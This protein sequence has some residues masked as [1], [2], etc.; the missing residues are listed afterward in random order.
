MNL[1]FKLFYVIIFYF[2]IAFSCPPAHC[3]CFWCT[4]CTW[5]DCCSFHQCP[6]FFSGRCLFSCYNDTCTSFS[7]LTMSL[8]SDMT[9]CDDTQKHTWL[10]LLLIRQS[11]LTIC[12]SEYQTHSA[13][14]SSNYSFPLSLHCRS[15]IHYPCC[16]LS[17]SVR[18]D[19]SLSLPLLLPTHAS[20]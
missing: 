7:S 20:L 12:P 4:W 11:A 13:C 3:C 17:L 16:A 9:P 18:I 2:T 10:C 8:C 1:N 19:L 14:Q 5:C 6:L 15:C